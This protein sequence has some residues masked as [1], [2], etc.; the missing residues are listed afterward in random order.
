MTSLSEAQLLYMDAGDQNQVLMLCGKPSEPSL[1]LAPP[2]AFLK[3]INGSLFLFLFCDF[4][5]TV[6]TG[7]RN[8]FL[9]KVRPYNCSSLF[10]LP[11]VSIT[12]TGGLTGAPL[13]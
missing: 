3:V 12:G 1:H 9:W 2:S 7:A 6:E 10:L 8:T 13:T 4:H 11:A 5:I